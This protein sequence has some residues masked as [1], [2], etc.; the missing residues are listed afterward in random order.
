MIVRET[1]QTE[2]GRSWVN[3]AGKLEGQDSKRMAAISGGQKEIIIC[4]KGREINID[5]NNDCES[6][7]ADSTT[8]RACIC[9]VKPG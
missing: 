1:Q 8:K 7:I 9:V 5:V 4:K 3:C 2:R 6:K